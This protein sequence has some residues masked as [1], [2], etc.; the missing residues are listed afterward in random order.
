MPNKQNL[1]PRQ[2]E[3]TE[4]L[5]G[6]LLI[7]AGAGAGK[8]KTLVHRIANLIE[9]GVRPEKILAITFTNKAAGEMRE[10]IAKSLVAGT[11]SPLACTFHALGV[12]ILRQH[13][14]AIG[15]SKYFSILDRDEAMSKIKQALK[16]AQFDPKK[17]EP[18]KVLSGI[19]KQKGD[20]KNFASFKANVGK[21]DF[22]SQML[23]TVWEKYEA[24]LVK[25][26]VVDFDDLLQK[27]VELLKKF[28]EV[29]EHYQ[30]KWSH[31]HIDEYQ[32]TNSTQYELTK[33]L[34]EKHNNICVVGDIDQSI[35]SWRGADYKNIMRFEKDYAEAKTIL[36]EE[37]YRSTKTILAAANEVIKK[38][39]NRKDKNLFTNNKDGEPIGLFYASTEEDEAL[40]VAVKAQDLVKQGISPDRIAV[41]YR[42][43]FQSRVLEEAFLKL[44]VPYQILGT[45]FYDRKE[46]K[47]AAALLKCAFNP[48]DITSLK[49]IINIPPR[50]I[51]TVTFEKIADGEEEFLPIKTKEKISGFRKKLAELKDF[52]EKN[53]P[54]ATIKYLIDNFSFR[55]LLAKEDDGEERLENLGELITL[56]SKYDDREAGDGIMDLISEISLASEQDNLK[57][58]GGVKLMTVHASKGLE[59]DYVFIPG[60][61]QDLFPHR[62]MGEEKRDEEEER[63][64]FYVALTRAREKLFLSCAESRMIFGSRNPSLPSEFLSD[65]DCALVEA[66]SGLGEIF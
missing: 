33:I 46:I 9:S 2:K 29:R 52:A 8:T 64:L 1:N 60:L 44:S 43:N 34:A 61:E 15:L 14:G 27:T 23:V 24:I 5:S 66:E 3:A 51:G 36:L 6:P 39:I 58:G 7:I 53:K 31:I 47:D 21:F 26:K 59:F 19:S 10:R 30:N 49:R 13:G 25:E 12:Q 37:N 41:L 55:E 45:R 17:F 48:E 62:G 11:R 16:E 57:G 28:P 65:I 32:D 63:R 18:R 50:G 42:A 22:W 4:I 20:G 40:F 38:N 54:S 56:A 35:Y